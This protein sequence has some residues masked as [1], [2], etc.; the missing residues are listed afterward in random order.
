MRTTTIVLLLAIP[1]LATAQPEKAVLRVVSPELPT[2]FA[3]TGIVTDS[4]RAAL[5]LVFESLVVVS[6][7]ADGQRHTRPVLAERLPAGDGVKFAFRLRDG[8]KWSTGEPIRA[9]DVRH[10]VKLLQADPAADLAWHDGVTP[11]DSPRDVRIELTHGSIEPWPWFT[12]RVVPQICRERELQTLDDDAFLKAPIG[13]GPFVVD[14]IAM[15]GVRAYLRFRTNPHYV[16]PAPPV[17]EIRWFASA[18]PAEIA[19]I[20]SDVVLGLSKIEK[21]RPLAV[22]SRRIEYVAL[23]QRHPALAEIEMRRFLGTAIRLEPS[24][25]GLAPADS[26]TSASRVPKSWHQPAVA[27]TL[28]RA[29]GSKRKSLELSLKFAGSRALADDLIAQWQSAAK[30]A[31]WDLRIE[32]TPLSAAELADALRGH[33]YDL[34]LTHEDAGDEL[35]RLAALFDPRTLAPGGS[36]LL[37]A[38]LPEPLRVELFRTRQFPRLVERV[39]N[40]HAHLYETMPLIPLRQATPITL[41]VGPRWQAAP[42][43]GTRPF[44][45]WST[46]RELP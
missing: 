30:S 37:G 44:A 10:T 16:G 34:A 29:L 1:A 19:K 15:E 42:N 24:A 4:E 40:L 9:T 2:R 33:D 31:G 12:F 21:L 7:D 17:R 28:A 41:G 13:S 25:N 20:A 39:H 36:N 14:G 46:W 18:D 3:P 11:G 23:N 43:D 27:S 32:P 45:D 35:P 38:V 8:L 6:T 22:P 26:W 5:D